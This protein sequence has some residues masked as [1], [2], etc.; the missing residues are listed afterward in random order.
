M[1]ENEIIEVINLTNV[2]GEKAHK[3]NKI[4]NNG[5]EKNL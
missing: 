5:E 4:N 1:T 2:L 3:K